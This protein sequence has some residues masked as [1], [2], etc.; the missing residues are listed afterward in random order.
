MPLVAV[1][2]CG[3]A[4]FLAATDAG[5][6]GAHAGAGGLRDG[7][8]DRTG[9][10]NS[11][12]CLTA[13]D[14]GGDPCVELIPGGYRV[15]VAPVPEA[16]TCSTPAGACCKSTDC[17]SQGQG[18]GKCI[19]G[20]VEPACGGPVVVPTNVCAADA[21]TS[22][23]DCTGAN[24]ICVPAGALDR[25]AARCLT[26]GCRFD[27]DCTAEPGGICVPVANPCCDAVLGLFCVYADGCRSNANC[28]TGSYCATDA[29]HA[30]CKVGAPVC[31]L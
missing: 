10:T 5:P 20:P 31:P 27:R 13:S 15:C 22:A 29:T 30:Y 4:E 16:T 21:C 17:P 12:D 18:P 6:D 19:L 11:G 14:C 26:G 1:L 28:M 24:P 2:A 3:G 23:S 8:S 9:L 7:A 25:K